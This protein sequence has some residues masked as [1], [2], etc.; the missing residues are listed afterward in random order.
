MIGDVLPTTPNESPNWHRL[1]RAIR[2]TWPNRHGRSSDV[3]TLVGCSGG[4]DSVALIRLLAELWAEESNVL[5][6]A[7]ETVTNPVAPLV[8]AHCNHG[9][10]GEESTAD[11]AFVR[12]LCDQLQL[13]L[14]IHHVSPPNNSATPGPVSDER[15][16]RQIRRDFFER[17]AKQHGCR[18]VAVAHSAD[19]QAETMLHHFIRG[20]GPL[21]LAGIAEVSELDTDIVVRRP[22]L[23]VRRD[24]LRDGLREIGQPWREDASNRHTIYTRNWIRHDVLPLIESRYPNA[25][26]AIHRAGALQ[27]EMNAMV[28]RLAERWLEAFTDFSCDRWTIHTERLSKSANPEKRMDDTNTACSWMIERPVIVAASQL[29]WDRL[30]WSRG[31]M[32]MQHWQRLTGLINDQSFWHTSDI[33]VSNGQAVDGIDHGGHFPGGICLSVEAKQLVLRSE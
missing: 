23:Q 13:P 1:R 4:A 7:N 30:G 5:N 3:A 16:L 12:Q 25:V 21:G 19:D 9:L 20:T 22:L 14:V 10:R 28:R 2:S 24:T 31:S 11:E 26:E 17:A 32:T 8:V 6:P 29:A 33:D 18:Y 27:H 15:T